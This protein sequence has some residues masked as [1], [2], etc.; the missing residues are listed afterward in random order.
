MVRRNRRSR[1]S[2]Y[3]PSE[4][5]SIEASANAAIALRDYSATEL[6]V[7]TGDSAHVI[8]SVG[9]WVHVIDFK[10]ENGWIRRNCLEREPAS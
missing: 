1:V 5:F 8:E 10:G 3:F 2:G 6:A 7:Q 9:P 4:W